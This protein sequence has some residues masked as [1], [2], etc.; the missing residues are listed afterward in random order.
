MTACFDP[1]GTF[2][3][4]CFILD[5][6]IEAET[7]SDIHVVLAAGYADES[8]RCAVL[9]VFSC[10]RFKHVYVMCKDLFV[11]DHETERLFT[12]V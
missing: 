6:K 5:F 12:L 8:L 1:S 7:E 3:A 9:F 10:F 2:H 11:V 4:K